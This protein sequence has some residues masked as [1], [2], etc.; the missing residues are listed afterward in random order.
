MKLNSIVFHTGRLNEIRSFYEEKL[1]LPTG[2]YVRE[3]K[4]LPD[5]SDNYV[6]YYVDGALLCFE[7]DFERTDVGTIVL[8]VPDFISFRKRIENLGI[9]VSAGNDNYFKIRDPDGR[10]LIIEPL[11]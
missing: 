1:Q 7:T 11:R 10:T 2:T 4:T 3:N 8:N 5:Y 9:E 6:N